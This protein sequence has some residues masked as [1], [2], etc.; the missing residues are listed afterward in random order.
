MAT[1]VHRK[2]D[3]KWESQLVDPA[4]LHNY[5]DNGFTLEKE[6]PK[7]TKAKPKAKKTNAS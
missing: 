7:K 3:G 4:R 2:V 5:T 1:W 6:E